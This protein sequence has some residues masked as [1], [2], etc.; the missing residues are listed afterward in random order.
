VDQLSIVY[1]ATARQDAC[2]D[3]ECDSA[4][5]GVD[6]VPYTQVRHERAGHWPEQPAIGQRLHPHYKHPSYD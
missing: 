4:G 3:W 1:L 6:L 5:Q 2:P